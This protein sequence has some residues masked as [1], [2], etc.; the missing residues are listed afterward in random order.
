MLPADR[1]PLPNRLV[2]GRVAAVLFLASGVV[3]AATLPLPGPP[4][5]NRPVLLG[6]SL[7]ALAIGGAA[8]AAP[9][10]RWPGSASLWLVPPALALIA[11]GNVYGGT[12]NYTYGVFFVVVFAWVGIGHA[13]WASL[14]LAPLAALAYVLPILAMAGD[15][16][17]GLASTAVVIPVA[18]CL[19]EATA[20]LTASL[21]RTAAQLGRRT[22]ELELVR[23]IAAA[24]NEARSVDDALRTALD[25]V[26]AHTRWPV[27]HAF[28]LDEE[29]GTGLVSSGIWSLADAR[30]FDTFRAVTEATRAGR[31]VGLPGKALSTGEPAWATDLAGDPSFLDGQVAVEL[32]IRASFVFPVLIGREVVAVLEFF[33]DRPVEPD[34][35]LLEIMANVGAQLG[36]VVERRRAA[37]AIRSEEIAQRAL[38][39]SLTGLPNMTLFTDHL[40]MA[41]ARLRR[42]PSTVAVLFVDLDRFKT[43]NDTLGHAAG[44]ALLVQVV[45]RIQHVVRPT[46][47]VARFGGDEF[48]ILCEEL[49]GKQEALLI[50]ERIT[51]ALADP[52][53]LDGRKV[54]IS[55]SIG[56]ALTAEPGRDP[57]ELIQDADAAMYRAKRQGRAR[58]EVFDARMRSQ[59]R[60]RRRVE[61][62]LRGALERD[63]L[64]LYVQPVVR[65]SDDSVVGAEALVRWRHPTRGLLTP[66]QFLPVAEE[67]GLVARIDDWML[68]R[69]T[70]WLRTWDASTPDGR[71][72]WVSLNLSFGQFE[73]PDLADSVDRAIRAAGVDPG[74]VC[75][76]VTENELVQD[77]ESAD[78]RLR[79]L[80]GVGVLL[81]IDRFGAGLA[82][83]AFVKRFPIDMVKVDR[84]LVAGL[85]AAG[86]EMAIVTGVVRTAAALGLHT[87]GQGVETEDQ[88]AAL[89]ALGCELAQGNLWARPQPAES[90]TRMLER[91]NVAI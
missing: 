67:S 68:R 80:K 56:V 21:R 13:R 42:H 8:W 84:A 76:E 75:L 74:S 79:A 12:V 24:S 65:L 22:A 43:V 17:T 77:L 58:Y 60:G 50:A 90:L 72:V 57:E 16:G 5:L 64:Q 61:N 28:V 55:V 27:G 3:S 25:L 32:D 71:P 91:R 62:A 86:Q 85:G 49:P 70:A 20:W 73:R 51:Q 1:M 59:A 89:R 45:L 35:G 37:Q 40:K 46:D 4:G 9:W 26:C 88:A 82:S 83:P 66:S 81:A 19:G 48:L 47:T 31:A 53:D 11:A 29:E 39:D 63:E 87:V 10:D 38:H 78:E 6:V 54:G 33:S 7:V 34:P 15:R 52:F 30:R 44:S 2:I 14:K 69:A 18:V 36:R 41:L 23:A